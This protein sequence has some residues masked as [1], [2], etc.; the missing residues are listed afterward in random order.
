MPTDTPLDLDGLERRLKVRLPSEDIAISVTDL[1]ALIALARSQDDL[2]AALEYA[3][4]ALQSICVDAQGASTA[5]APEQGLE[6]IFNR[7]S[8][9]SSVLATHFRPLPTPP[10]PEQTN[11]D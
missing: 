8:E 9:A 7:A 6:A 4:D 10:S 3:R 5:G 1:R 2:L 11:A